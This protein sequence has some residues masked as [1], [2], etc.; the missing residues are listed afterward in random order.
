MCGNVSADLQVGARVQ[1]LG[2]GSRRVGTAWRWVG[3]VPMVAAAAVAVVR[4]G[5]S[6]VLVRRE[7]CATAM[8]VQEVCRSFVVTPGAVEMKASSASIF[9]GEVWKWNYYDAG[10]GKGKRMSPVGGQDL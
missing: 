8:K 10:P 5:S 3:A 1:M 6:R 4:S 9:G 2:M 7:R